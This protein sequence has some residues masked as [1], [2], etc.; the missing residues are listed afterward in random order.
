MAP[1]IEQTR[2]GG[3]AVIAVTVASTGAATIPGP[4]ARAGQRLVFLTIAL[5]GWGGCVWI[6]HRGGLTRRVLLAAA[7][8]GA[9]LAL[10]APPVGSTDVSSY[11][12]YGRMVA[13]H[14]ASPYTHVPA[15]YPND[16]WYARMATF[17]HHTGSVYGPLFTGVSA[18][19]MAVAGTSFL[20]TRLFFQ[21]LAA[22]AF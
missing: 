14:H 9:A 11:A 4:Q 19:A 1:S 20:A 12:V 13:V 5:V 21:L 16:P 3:W 7:V 8:G 6:A 15:D 18:A 2:L 10:I 17:W 22:L